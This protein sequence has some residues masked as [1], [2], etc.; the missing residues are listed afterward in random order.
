MLSWKLLSLIEFYR[1][2][3]YCS[4]LMRYVILGIMQDY[5]SNGYRKQANSY[6]PTDFCFRHP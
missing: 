1:I 3:E 6:S 5:A 4:K 2:L